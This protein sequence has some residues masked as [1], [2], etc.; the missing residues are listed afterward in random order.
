M[1]CI[2]SAGKRVRQDLQAMESE[3]KAKQAE[4][5]AGAMSLDDKSN[6]LVQLRICESQVC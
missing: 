4:I 2:K 6:A 3:N 1:D 5:A